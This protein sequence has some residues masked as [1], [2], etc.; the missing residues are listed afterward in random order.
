MTRTIDIEKELAP[1]P[2][3]TDYEALHIGPGRTFRPHLPHEH[4]EAASDEKGAEVQ[5]RLLRALNDL[6]QGLQD[7]D[8]HGQPAYPTRDDSSREPDAPH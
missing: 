6:S 8:M 7:T 4:D 3:I 5:D 2:V 1:D